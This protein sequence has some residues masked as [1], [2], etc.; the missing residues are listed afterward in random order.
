MTSPERQLEEE[1]LQKLRDLKYE[2][3]ND[4]RNRAAMEENFR[5]KFDALNNVRLTQG[6]FQRLLVEIVTPDVFT[7]AHT[8]RKY[9][10][11]TCW[12]RSR[13]RWRA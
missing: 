4:I 5:K 10:W 8:L 2:H 6:E 11:A 1:L 13:G 12:P 7:A 9:R 3:R